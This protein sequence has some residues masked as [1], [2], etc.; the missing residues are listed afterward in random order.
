MYKD[1]DK[2]R[3]ANKEASQRRR[4]Q[5]KALAHAV[6]PCQSVIGKP[7]GM[8][9][10][11]MTVID[12]PPNV[13]PNAAQRLKRGKD[14]KVFAD[15]PSDVQKSIDRM[16]INKDGTVNQ[17]IK[18]NRTAIAISYQ[19]MFPGRYYPSHRDFEGVGE[20]LSLVTG[21]PGDVDYNGVCTEAWRAE[22]GR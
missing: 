4:D 2:Q 14:I 9:N 8:T 17:T 15:L 6:I 18:A 13:I 16:S 21:K 7:D 11:G 22:R 3:K 5:L 20:Q 10:Q 12:E 19:H 1:K